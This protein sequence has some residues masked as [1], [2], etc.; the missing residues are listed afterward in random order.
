MRSTA[1]VR[2]L[3]IVGTVL[4]ALGLIAGHMNRHLLDGPTFAGHVDQIRT[5]AAV[6]GLLGESISTQIVGANP[7]LVA[8][9]PLIDDVATRVAGSDV[10]SGP[11]RLAAQAAHRVLT[12]GDP[13]PVVL[14]IADTGGVA[15]AVLAAV[16]PERATAVTGVSVTLLNVGDQ[17]LGRAPFETLRLAGVLAWVFPLAALASFGAAL[18][19]SRRRWRTGA[20]IGRALVGG[21]VVVGLLLAIGGFAVRRLDDGVISGAVTRAAWGEVMNPMWW[22]VAVLAAVG[23]TMVLACEPSGPRALARLAARARA[24]LLGRPSKPVGVVTRALIAGLVGVAALLDP[25]GLVELAI[26]AGGVVLVLFAISQIAS[27]ARAS[28][29]DAEAESGESEQ[30]AQQTTRWAIPRP[31]ALIVVAL[32]GLA[33]VA[34]G[35]AQGRPGGP[36]E[37]MTS[38]SGLVCNGHAELCDRGFDEVAYAATHNSMSAVTE[39]RW[40]LPEQ[41]DRIPVQLDQGVRALLI[42][43]WSGHQAGEIVRTAP[44]SHDEALR[45]AEDKLGPDVVAAA[46]RVADAIAGEVEGPEKRFLCHGLCE[47]GSTP[48]IDNLVQIRDWMLAHPDEVVT[49]FIQDETEA[50]LIAADI[51]AAGLL[52]L[53]YEPVLGEPW[54]TLAEMITS[55]QRLVVMLEEGSGGPD[56]PWLVNGFEHT[57]DT[58]FVFPT[59][60]SFSCELNRGPADA[61]LFLLNHWLAGFTSLVSDAQLVNGRDVL[62]PRA[63]TCRAERGQIPNFVAVD[64]VTLG[65]V[66]EVVDVLN[67]VD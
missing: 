53:V 67:G 49:L 36:V 18:L 65:D 12:D 14:R 15:T 38:G 19:L 10:W 7:D 41:S 57:Q 22:G 35:I 52:P 1:I 42:D 8:V 29:A 32:A 17:G 58:P 43:V 27:L 24:A 39:P 62:L 25:L 13:S 63:E 44:G 16:A 66:F 51:E 50:S 37:L 60:E 21:A 46:L 59:V 4:A 48:F 56:A 61:P 2:V 5:D 26:M 20:A 23:S 6:S 31:A 55:G 30:P 33:V 11:T 45:V 64:F 54:P 3:I 28:R 47:T 40:F 34:G 9:R